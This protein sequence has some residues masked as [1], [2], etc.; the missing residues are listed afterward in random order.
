[1]EVD[2]GEE[3]SRVGEMTQT[4]LETL[5]FG[6]FT[7]D[8]RRRTLSHNGQ[9]LFI[10]SRAFDILALLASRP[11]E[12]IP[13]GEIISAVW[14][15]ITIEEVSLR[16]H[17]TNLRKLLA[18][19]SDDDGER[20]ITTVVGRGYCFVGEINASVEPAAMVQ[21]TPLA[22]QMALPAKTETVVGRSDEYVE[23]V[24]LLGSARCVTICGP[25]GV[26]KTTLA[27][28]VAQRAR[29][30]L[31]EVY[32]VDL[33]S[34]SDG[35]LVESTILATMKAQASAGTADVSI[36]SLAYERC[37][38]VLDTCEHL[39]DEVAAVVA[40][41]IAAAPPA[42]ILCTSR[43][44]L[45]IDG[46]I[47]YKLSPLACAPDDAPDTASVQNYPATQLFLRR[48]GASG[49]NIDLS[50]EDA[51]VVAAICRKLDGLPL[52]IEL[53]ASRVASYGLHKILELLED[54]IPFSWQG[55][56]TAPS[57]QKSLKAAMDWSYGLLSDVERETLRVC[58]AFTGFFTFKA[59]QAVAASVDEASLLNA[60]D[61]LVTKSLLL[62]APLRRSMRYRLLDTTRAYAHR[63]AQELEEATV[64]AERH[65]D[66]YLR[67]LQSKGLVWPSMLDDEQRDLN[68][69]GLSNVRAALSWS[70]DTENHADLAI[71][72]ATAAG[73]MFLSFTLIEECKQ[74]M[75]K[76]LKLI[77]NLGSDPLSEM[78]LQ[79][80][81]GVALMFMRT[82]LDTSRRSLERSVEVA[83]LHGD[84][85]YRF[86][87]R[88]PLTMYYISVG[89]FRAAIARGEEAVKIAETM[90]DVAA[91]AQS[92][93][94]LADLVHFT[95]DLRRTR[96][97]FDR[98]PTKGMGEQRA[99][100][101]FGFEQV[102]RG[103]VI[104]A[105][106]MWLQGDP[107]GAN[108]VL[109]ESIIGVQRTN[110]PLSLSIA[111]MW[112]ANLYLLHGDLAAAENCIDI[113]SECAISYSLPAHRAVG[114][115][116]RGGLMVL[117]GDIGNGVE[118][119]RRA[120][121]ECDRLTYRL[122]QTPLTIAL[123][124]GLLRRG[125]PTEALTILEDLVRSIATQGD[126]IYLPEVLRLKGKAI[127]MLDGSREAVEDCFLRSLTLSRSQGAVA[128]ELRTTIDVAAGH[129]ERGQNE[130]AAELLR[131]SMA[132][133]ESGGSADLD[134]ASSWLSKLYAR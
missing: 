125:S 113:V 36:A 62:A 9:R 98:L 3:F 18:G 19:A 108:E 103:Q 84:P 85:R 88:S 2:H 74:W 83:D 69:A 10:G 68:F 17:I 39:I 32:V 91:Q 21:A 106:T 38:L 101:I 114:Q 31:G 71:R 43:E 34:V 42:S 26:G 53:T 86:S 16:F 58:S 104:L 75:A 130:G 100:R 107:R 51:F 41:L 23:V 6:S 8:R 127:R 65:A 27:T 22:L 94:G 60:I 4:I 78:H 37:L 49:S 67:W 111:A 47:V 35:K 110:H 52:A 96:Q 87:L 90:D 115:G 133:F 25:G 28:L 1:M 97:Y 99:D 124:D 46:E 118:Y 14:P 7:L 30:S 109:R 122:Q 70:F 73:P 131:N 81:L 13:K 29:A 59:L 15:G 44:P 57:R 105:R 48:A 129:A 79:S 66:H 11:N 82:E 126:E 102:K 116:Y 56:R 76:A 61:G 128:W 120:V 33:G 89:E 63:L 93:W 54:E 95:G 64:L 121:A 92:Y 117:D 50:P 80:A 40:S 77:E 112:A 132:K 119:L 72:L 20:L 45:Q 55:Q 123:A 12:V 24:S 134:L 5:S